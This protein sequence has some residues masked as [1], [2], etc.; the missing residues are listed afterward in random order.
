MTT[1]KTTF[2]VPRRCASWMAGL[3]LASVIAATPASARQ[4]PDSCRCVD[5]DGVEIERC[6]CFRT[7]RLDAFVGSWAPDA[8][9]PRLGLSVDVSRASGGDGVEVTSVLPGGPAAEAG[10]REGDVITSI[11]GRALSTSLGAEAERDFDLDR[12]LPVQRLLAIAGDLEPGQEVEIVYTREG[13]RQ[14][15]IVEAVDLA[16]SWGG[17]FAMVM[18]PWEEGRLGD[19]LRAFSTFG[20]GSGLH[21]LGGLGLGLVEVDPELGAYFGTDRGVLVTEVG[22]GSG[23]GLRPGDVVVRIGSRPVTTAEGFRRILASY[24]PREDIELHVRRGGEET[25]VTGRLRY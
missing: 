12:S 14:A 16:D 6:T 20:D 7:P 8:Q 13:E 24:D 4:D 15:A 1:M 18:P 5:A 3:A 21:G 22:R 10:I 11:D 19:Q 25:I 2:E 9:R 17:R 23:L